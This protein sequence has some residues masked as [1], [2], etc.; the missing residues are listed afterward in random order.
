M[1]APDHAE[2]AEAFR[3]YARAFEQLDPAAVVPY[4][5]QPA[6]LVSPQGVVG[7]ATAA[8]VEQFFRRVMGELRAQGYARSEFPALTERR[9]GADLAVV[10]GVGSWKKATG[11]ELRRFGLTYTLCRTDKT[12]RIVLAAI[13]EP[14][15][16]AD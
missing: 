10:S 13:H 6:I 2:A 9:L 7:L 14:G 15:K 3:Q 1:E 4:F 16:G 12:W 11:E 8:E 5:N